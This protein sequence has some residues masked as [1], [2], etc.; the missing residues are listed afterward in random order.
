MIIYSY[1]LQLVAI[2]F[3]Q[4]LIKYNLVHEV[5]MRILVAS[6]HAVYEMYNKW[7]Q[8]DDLIYNFTI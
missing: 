3:E 2:L 4:L 8:I 5:N 1:E 6:F 7:I